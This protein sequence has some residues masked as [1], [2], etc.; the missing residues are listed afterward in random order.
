MGQCSPEF[1]VGVQ[2]QATIDTAWTIAANFVAP[3]SVF[4]CQLMASAAP[5][6]KH[7]GV[8]SGVLPL[9]RL[10]STEARPTIVIRNEMVSW[11]RSRNERCG[12]F[13]LAC[14]DRPSAQFG[15][16]KG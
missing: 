13:N 10:W 11:E 4:Q 15:C 8:A 9:A 16:A 12:T 3:V 6:G 1:A 7:H 14:A 5:I 2:E